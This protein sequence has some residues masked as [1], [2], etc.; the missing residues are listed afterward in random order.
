MTAVSFAG[1]RGYEA[2]GLIGA[3]VGAVVLG[4][5]SIWLARRR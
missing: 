4:G 3:V 2:T 5:L 1:Q